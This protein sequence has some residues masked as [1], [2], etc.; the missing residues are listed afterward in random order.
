MLFRSGRWVTGLEGDLSWVGNAR[1]RIWDPGG[2]ARYDEVELLWTGHIRG[3]VGYLVDQY[4]IFATGGAAF[5]GTKASHFGP[6]TGGSQIW[7]EDTVRTGYS[8]GGGLERAF[9]NNWN[10]R[11]EYLYDHFD[12]KHYDWIPNTRYSNSDL[13]TN[14][15]RV[16]FVYRPL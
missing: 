1:D 15:V 14:T 6:V 8:V 5:A 7:S 11:I 10:F 3:R 2:S 16:S 12:S 13:T 9:T 4:L